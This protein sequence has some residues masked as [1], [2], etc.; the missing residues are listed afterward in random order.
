MINLVVGNWQYQE[1][2]TNLWREYRRHQIR[3]HNIL[4]FQNKQQDEHYLFYCVHTAHGLWAI[5]EIPLS[6]DILSSSSL[7]VDV[8]GFG[9]EQVGSS[10][11]PLCS[12]SG[13]DWLP[14]CPLVWLSVCLLLWLSV[15][16]LIC[17]WWPLER[18]TLLSVNNMHV[19]RSSSNVKVS[20]RII[21]TTQRSAVKCF[22]SELFG[23]R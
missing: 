16:P 5:P 23:W 1:S 3:K 6:M 13:L 18:G 8:P 12:L 22:I 11:L 4:G 21:K 14:V 17:S 2:E 9:E 19:I 15:C 7:V 10:T 20:S